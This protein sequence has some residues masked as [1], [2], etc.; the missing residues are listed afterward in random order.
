MSILIYVLAAYL[1][2]CWLWGIY[3][4]VRLYAGRRVGRVVRGQGLGPRIVRPLTASV[5]TNSKATD[6]PATTAKPIAE[7][8][9]A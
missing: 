8:R 5:D 4:A 1:A 2:V 9:A 6:R 3:L 7:S